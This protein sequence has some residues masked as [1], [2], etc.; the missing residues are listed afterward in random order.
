MMLLK[1]MEVVLEVSS[2]LVKALKNLG[3]SADCLVEGLAFH[4]A[5]DDVALH[6]HATSKGQCEV[7]CCLL[8]DAVVLETVA[9]LELPVVADQALL[10]LRDALSVRGDSLDV[11]GGVR[12]LDI[13]RG[14]LASGG[15]HE[16]LHVRV[17]VARVLVVGVVVGVFGVGVVGVGVVGVVGVVVVLALALVADHALADLFNH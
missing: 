15:R 17:V 7:K 9:I 14:G 11:V 10:L 4:D 12:G 16:D 8:L 1:S 3:W 6:G 13:H 5:F 2:A